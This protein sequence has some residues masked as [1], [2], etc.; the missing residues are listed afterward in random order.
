MQ[1]ALKEIAIFAD[2]VER[3]SESAFLRICAGAK[4]F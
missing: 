1:A 4:K 2:I 3:T